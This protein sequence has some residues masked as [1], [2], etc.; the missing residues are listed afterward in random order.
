M[1]LQAWWDIFQLIR[2]GHY[3]QQR[4]IS[5]KKDKLC[6]LELVKCFRVNWLRVWFLIAKTNHV[7]NEEG[8]LPSS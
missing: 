8:T 1:E 2:Q 3:L 6:C 5:N 7:F 4:I